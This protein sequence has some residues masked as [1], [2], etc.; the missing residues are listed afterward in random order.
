MGRLNRDQKRIKAAQ[1]LA[2]A[3]KARPETEK[4]VTGV[5]MSPSGQLFF[6][7]RRGVALPFVS[8][9]AGRD[10]ID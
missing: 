8:M 4:Y 6:I 10:A 9:G 3:G 7:N 1:A 2:N 5:W